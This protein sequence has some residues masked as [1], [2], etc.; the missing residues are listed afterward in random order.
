L[1]APIQYEGFLP[2]DELQKRL[3]LCRALLMTPR[4]L[5]AF[6]NVAIEARLVVCQ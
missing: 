1:D 6:G 4:W 2:T 5:E 3:R